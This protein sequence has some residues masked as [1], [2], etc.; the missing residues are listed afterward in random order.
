MKNLI[1]SAL[2]VAFVAPAAP[3]RAQVAVD[4]RIGFPAPPPLVV[5]TPGVQ[6]VPD[7]DEEVFFVDGWYWLRRDASW[8]RTR[9]YRGGWVAVPPRAVPAR[10]VRLPPGEYKHWRKE[11]E[12]AQRE[13]EKADRKAWKEQAK[14]DRK[15]WKDQEK[16]EEKAHKHHGKH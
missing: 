12:K 3:A 7:Y 9:N 15:A 4:V 8:Y 5:V 2:V 1:L 13:A 10:L 11:Q 16:A 6:V 14:A